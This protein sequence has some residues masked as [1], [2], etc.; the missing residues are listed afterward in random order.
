M[1]WIVQLGIALS[2]IIVVGGLTFYFAIGGF[3][4][5]MEREEAKQKE[6]HDRMDALERRLSDLQDIV[7]ALDEKAGNLRPENALETGSLQ[8][9]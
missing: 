4:T 1:G 2:M 6:D 5:K 7:L 8:T 9:R 3:I